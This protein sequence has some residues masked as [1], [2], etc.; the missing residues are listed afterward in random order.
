MWEKL[1][2]WL[3]RPHTT[4]IDSNNNSM[5]EDELKILEK[6]ANSNLPKDITAFY[7]SSSVRLW[8]TLKEDLAPLEC[9]NLGFGGATTRDCIEQAAR[10][11]HPTQAEQVVIYVGDNDI[12]GGATAER[13]FNNTKKL[14]EDACK[15]MPNTS[16]MYVSIKPSPSRYHLKD[17]IEEAN[18]KI[19]AFVATKENISYLNIY[20]PMILED[21]SVDPSL[22]VEDD[23]HMNE[24]GYAL[25]TGLFRDALMLV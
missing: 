3:R 16:F 19:E 11:L 10:V 4:R 24:K 21:G 12:G 13:V 22:F 20:D 5:F 6:A 9:I 1:L 18:S 7:G 8:G 23:L 14:Y 17:V 2:N 25:W 15:A